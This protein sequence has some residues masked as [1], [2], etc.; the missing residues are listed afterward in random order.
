MFFIS[1]IFPIH[2]FFILYIAL[3][4][5]A[6]VYEKNQPELALFILVKLVDYILALTPVSDNKKSTTHDLEDLVMWT[7]KSASYSSAKEK[8][9][10]S[11]RD[12]IGQGT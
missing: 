6:I 9:V 5:L 8:Q 4:F 11:K 3:H 12:K 1:S 10:E 2:S 7:L